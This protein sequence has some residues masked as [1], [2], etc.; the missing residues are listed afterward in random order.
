MAL[1]RLLVCPVR[2]FHRRSTFRVTDFRWRLLEVMADINSWGRKMRA[3]DASVM[4]AYGLGKAQRLLDID[5]RSRLFCH[6]DQPLNQVHR[7]LGIG[8]PPSTPDWAAWALRS[9]RLSRAA[10]DGFGFGVLERLRQWMDAAA[11]NRR[12]RGV[13]KALRSIRLPDFAGSPHR[14]PSCHLSGR[15]VAHLREEVDARPM[16]TEYGDEALGERRSE[17]QADTDGA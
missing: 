3:R 13:V 7:D 1:A 4:Q 12:R 11:H 14:Q 6:G 5:A 17:R 9:R 15:R 10:A 16:A 8:G 2:C